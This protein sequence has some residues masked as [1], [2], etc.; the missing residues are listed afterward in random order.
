MR[1]VK[2]QIQADTTQA[3]AQ[4]RALTGALS[5]LDAI[6]KRSAQG[7]LQGPGIAMLNPQTVNSVSG[8][9]A[10][11]AQVMPQVQTGALT[12]TVS[13][14]ATPAAKKDKFGEAMKKLNDYTTKMAEKEFNLFAD[15]LAK[16]FSDAFSALIEHGLKAGLKSLTTSLKGLFG[17]L[18]KSLVGD[19]AERIKKSIATSI[20]GIFDKGGGGLKVGAVSTGQ[21]TGTTTTGGTGGTTTTTS[22]GGSTSSTTGGLGVS[23]PPFMNSGGSSGS[24]WQNGAAA[25]MLMKSGQLGFPTG[26]IKANTPPIANPTGTTNGGATTKGGV[27]LPAN[28]SWGS[29]GKMIG[30]MAPALGSSL[31]GMLGGTSLVGSLM[32]SVGGLMAGTALGIATGAISTTSGMMGSLVGALGG[33]TMATGI[34]AGVGVALMIGAYLFGKT[35]QRKADEKTRN[36]AMLDAF[37]ALD[38]ILKQ[39]GSDQMEGAAAINQANQIRKQYL[40]QMSQLKDKK[41]RNIALKD[42]S[43][44]DVKITQIKQAADQQTARKAMDAKLVP[45][46]ADGGFVGAGFVGGAG[47]KVLGSDGAFM[48]PFRGRVP[49]IYDRRDDFLARLTGNEVVLTPDV[50]MPIAPYLKQKRVPG[51]AGGGMV[52]TS[53]F[54]GSGQASSSQAIVIEELTIHLSNQFGADSAAKILDVGLKTPEG[55]QAVVRSVRTHIGESGLADG[56]VRDINNVNERG[57]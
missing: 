5:Q 22:G 24:T 11:M 41:T 39:V 4:V 26:I 48:Q 25:E 57:F 43:R 46:F 49:G 18:L 31:G 3:T 27:N 29:L 53:G 42:V 34:L 52:D 32:G 17:S 51:F 7:F 28:F 6:A 15:G 13:D 44:I 56:V 35:K 8:Q 54:T 36:Q 55:R 37:S 1:I 16:S 33:A 20:K 47:Y 12:G 2:V 9:Q 19:I 23:I 40:D 38:D 30:S 10:A 14:P 45:T 50:W 21:T